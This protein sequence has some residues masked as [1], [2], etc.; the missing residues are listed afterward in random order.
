MSAPLPELLTPQE[1]AD[2]LKVSVDTVR[3]LYNRG[4]LE[5]TYVGRL[6]RIASADVVAYLNRHRRRVNPPAAEPVAP[7]P[8]PRGRG[9]R[10]TGGNDLLRRDR[11]ERLARQYR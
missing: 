11:I 5:P 8:R 1:V 3:A 6:V 4:E 2:R 7:S 10:G 9:K